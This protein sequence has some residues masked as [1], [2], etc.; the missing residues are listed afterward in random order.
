MNFRIE[1]IE[2]AGADGRPRSLTN[3]Q[4]AV[5]VLDAYD[6]REAVSL[7]ADRVGGT[8]VGE[9]SAIHMHAASA[10]LKIGKRVLSIQALSD[11]DSDPSTPR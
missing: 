4:A 1:S 9:C 3:Q 6:A 8:L 5:E 11:L 7:Y 2:L 10:T